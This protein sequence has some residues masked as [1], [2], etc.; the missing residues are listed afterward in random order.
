MELTANTVPNTQ[1]LIRDLFGRYDVAAATFIVPQ[2]ETA[3]FAKMTASER[4]DMINGV[5]GLNEIWDGV[6]KKASAKNSSAAR[7]Y[8]RLGDVRDSKVQDLAP[9]PHDNELHATKSQ[10]EADIKAC[11]EEI[12]QAEE[13]CQRGSIRNSK[14]P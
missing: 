13:E 14:P 5:L 11:Q 1:A 4:R 9:I 6:Y 8:Q 3:R 12:D 2:G 7:E 10:A